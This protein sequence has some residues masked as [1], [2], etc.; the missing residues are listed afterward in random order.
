M[1]KEIRRNQHPI[2]TVISV[3]D[4]KDLKLILKR[5]RM[6]RANFRKKML[7]RAN[8]EKQRAYWREWRKKNAQKNY[9]RQR[10]WREANRE[11]IRAYDRKYFQL[12]PAIQEYRAQK[13]REYRARK[14]LARMA[15]A[16]PVEANDVGRALQAGARNGAGGA[17][18]KAA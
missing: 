4:E 14:K 8:P 1:R 12:N 3:D 16:L 13:N 10:K 2:R 9:E 11:R 15:N 6:E 7:R 18:R 5:A 17:E